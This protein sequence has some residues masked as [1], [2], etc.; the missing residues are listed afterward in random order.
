MPSTQS[1]LFWVLIALSLAFFLLWSLKIGDREIAIERSPQNSPAPELTTNY[2]LFGES[3]Q[4]DEVKEVKIIPEILSNETSILSSLSKTKDEQQQN[5][6]DSNKRLANPPREIKALYATSWTAGSAKQIDY[7]LKIIKKN[8]LN[9]I[10]IDVKDFSGHL[11]LKANLKETLTI[12]AEQNRIADFQGLV[13]KLHDQGIYVITRIAVFQDS[14]LAHAR[15]QLAVK[16]K[17]TGGIWLDR[18]GLSW[19][20]PASKEVWKYNSQIAKKI[21]S[22]GVDELNF[23]YIRFP[24]DGDLSDMSFPEWDAKTPKKEII[25]NFFAFLSDEMRSNGSDIKISADLFGLTAVNYDDLG[26]GQILEYAAPHFDYICPMVYPSHYASGFLNF[27]NPADHPYEVIHYSMQSA[28]KRLDKLFE[29]CAA[30]ATATI[31]VSATSTEIKT[32]AA[33]L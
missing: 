14:L 17:K 11:A 13:N 16:S 33:S 3:P 1:K 23:D 4:S 18:K 12:G 20:D 6:N 5:N 10:V 19:V 8:N 22:Y 25:K 2:T 29:Q 27:K 26:I 32:L 30:N 28:K 21:A 24:S 9:A 7:L 31:A 15:P